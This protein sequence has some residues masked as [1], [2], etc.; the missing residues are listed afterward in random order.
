MSLLCWIMGHNWRYQRCERC[1][2]WRDMPARA[3]APAPSPRKV[4]VLKIWPQFAPSVAHG[5]K[6]FEV[7]LDDGRDFKVGDLCM[8]CVF[9]PIAQQYG[10]LRIHALI[11]YVLPGGQFGIQEGYVVFGHKVLSITQDHSNAVP[12]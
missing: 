2:A 4:H 10:S 11:T 8:Y 3:D 12:S 6:P 5:D 1:N 9:D 7:R